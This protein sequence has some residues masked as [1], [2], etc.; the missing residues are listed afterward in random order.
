MIGRGHQLYLQDERDA[1][2]M[3]AGKASTEMSCCKEKKA[4]IIGLGVVSG[5]LQLQLEQVHSAGGKCS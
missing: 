1:D 3:Y 4:K 5:R 2:K